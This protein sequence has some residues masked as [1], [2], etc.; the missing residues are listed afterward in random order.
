MKGLRWQNMCSICSSVAKVPWSPVQHCK[1]QMRQWKSQSQAQESCTGVGEGEE[2]KEGR[3]GQQR[4]WVG[5]MGMGGGGIGAQAHTISKPPSQARSDPPAQINVPAIEV[6]Q[7]CW[8]VAAAEAY[9]RTKGQMSSYPEDT[10]IS[11]KSP[12]GYIKS[13]TG[14]TETLHRDL[15]RIGVS[16][17]DRTQQMYQHSKDNTLYNITVNPTLRIRDWQ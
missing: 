13:S 11:Q 4:I 8:S 6:A 15:G 1:A 14:T 16:V 3:I 10:F 12:A 7:V 5:R 17:K 2:R 9:P